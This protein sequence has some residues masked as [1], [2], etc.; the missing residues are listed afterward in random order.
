MRLKIWK[1]LT[2]ALG[3]ACLIIKI[4]FF[5]AHE[6]NVMRVLF[7]NTPSGFRTDFTSIKYLGIKNNFN[8]ISRHKDLLK[9]VGK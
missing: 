5:D 9:H 2:R 4:Y 3:P 7:I 8:H 6:F 1:Y